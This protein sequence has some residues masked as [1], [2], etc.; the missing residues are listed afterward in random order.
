LYLP[1]EM[2][3]IAAEAHARLGNLPQARILINQVRTQ[4]S[5][6]VDEPVAGLTARTDAQLATLDAVL[7]QIAYERRYELYMQGLRWED[8]RRLPVTTSVTMEF[9]PLPASEC[10]T[11][12]NASGLGGCPIRE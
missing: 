11:N 8:T 6:T 10:R 12:T 7:R 1:D 4:T 9:L 2:K 3:L 5:S